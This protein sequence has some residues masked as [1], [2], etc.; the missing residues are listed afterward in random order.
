MWNCKME[1]AGVVSRADDSL[2]MESSAFVSLLAF[3]FPNLYPVCFGGWGCRVCEAAW[4]GC[5]VL[6]CSPFSLPVPL[7]VLVNL[8]I[9]LI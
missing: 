8:R 7:L 1:K 9:F 4:E 5:A 6:M 2:F 3:F